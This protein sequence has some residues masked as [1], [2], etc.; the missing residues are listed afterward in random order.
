MLMPLT[1]SFLLFFSATARINGDDIHK[2]TYHHNRDFLRKK[3]TQH[4]NKIESENP[5]HKQQVDR[6]SKKSKIVGGVDADIGKYPFFVS[7]GGCGASLVAR[8]IILSAAHCKTN[9]E[10]VVSIG[11]SRKEGNIGLGLE[12]TITQMITHPKYDVYSIDYDY[13]LMKLDQPIEL[14]DTFATS[15]FIQLNSDNDVPRNNQNLKVIG[16]GKLS[17]FDSNTDFPSRL[18]EVKVKAIP[19]DDCNGYSNY[20]GQ[21]NNKTMFCAGTAA[22][23]KDSCQ[24]DSGGPMF[25]EK[26]PNVF[27]QVG[28]VSWG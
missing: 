5:K 22:G 19:T 12:R 14:D 2:E 23:G 1:S 21:V 24:G 27:V 3:F 28:I 11:Q 9:R 25:Y 17:Q 7:W 16:F 8:D 6:N 20:D 18:Q 15:P 13:M 10:T 4:E 26:N